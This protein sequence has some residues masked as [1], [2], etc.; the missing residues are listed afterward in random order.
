MGNKEV[1]DKIKKN[2][3]GEAKRLH[4]VLAKALKML[5]D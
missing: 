2:M 1:I 4:L 3:S 5:A